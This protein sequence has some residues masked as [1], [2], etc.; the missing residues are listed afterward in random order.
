MK[1][2]RVTLGGRLG[3]DPEVQGERVKFSLATDD[4][5]KRATDNEKVEVTNWHHIVC[6]GKLGE[7]IAKYCRKGDEIIVHGSLSYREH[8]GKWYTNIKATEFSFVS[9]PKRNVENTSETTSKASQ[10]DTEPDDLPF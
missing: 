2:N 6:F 9:S 10:N 1:L 3:G 8:E 4:S 7:I 5:Y